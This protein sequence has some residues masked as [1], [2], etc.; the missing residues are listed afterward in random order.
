MKGWLREMRNLAGIIGCCVLGLGL[1]G[2]RAVAQDDALLRA[3]EARRTAMGMGAMEQPCIDKLFRAHR[4]K[5]SPATILNADFESVGVGGGPNNWVTA[6]IPALRTEAIEG[7]GTNH[8]ARI[9]RVSYY[10][11]L[12]T[13]PVPA[14]QTFTVGARVR[15]EYGEVR[16]ALYFEGATAQVVTLRFRFVSRSGVAPQDWGPMYAS[17]TRQPDEGFFGFIVR[18]AADVSWADMDDLFVVTEE[19]GNGGFEADESGADP[20]VRW[21]LTGD[22][23]LTMAEPLEGTTSLSLGSGA[24]AERLVAHTPY[25]AEYFLAGRCDGELQVSEARLTSGGDAAEPVYTQ[26]VTPGVGGKF[27]IPSIPLSTDA[28]AAVV[29]VENTGGADVRV[30]ELSRG[31][32][33][34]W[35]RRFEPVANSP[36]PSTRLTAAWPGKLVAAEVAILDSNQVEQDRLTNGDLQHDGTSVWAEYD[37]G[38]LPAGN[39]TA[40]FELES[41]DGII[42]VDRAFRIE[43]PAAFPTRL[44]DLNFPEFAR[45]PWMWL[46]PFTAET[47]AQVDT[48]D[49]IEGRLAAA[50]DDGFNFFFIIAGYFQLPM[51]KEAAER[52]GV[53]YIVGSPEFW[54]LF[55]EVYGNQT[56]EP[57]IATRELGGFDALLESEL[58][59]GIYLFDEPNTGGATMVQR[60]QGAALMMQAEG[61]YPAGMTFLS[62]GFASAGANFPIHSTYTYPIYHRQLSGTDSILDSLNIILP[63]IAEANTLGR[64]YWLGTQGFGHLGNNGV[65]TPEECTAQLGTGLVAGMRGYWP[66]LYTSLG[67]LA[68]LRTHAYGETDRLVAYRHFNARVAALDDLLMALPQARSAPPQSNV[69]ARVAQH[70]TGGPHALVANYHVDRPLQVTVQASASTR[71]INVETG[72][73]TAEGTSHVALLPAGDWAIFRFENG[74]TPTEFTG[75]TQAGSSAERPAAVAF[76]ASLTTPADP[77]SLTIKPDGTAVAYV[78]DQ[79]HRVS[80]IATGSIG[81]TLLDETNLAFLGY[82]RYLDNTRLVLGSRWLGPRVY[83]QTGTI[84]SPLHTLL[85]ESGNG[86]DLLLNGNEAW[87]S[88]NYWGVSRVDFSGVSG[89]TRVAHIFSSDNDFRS[90]HGPF[91]DGSV[92]GVETVRGLI[93]LE[94][95]GG[96]ITEERLTPTSAYEYATMSPGGRIAVGKLDRKLSVYDIGADGRIAD[97]TLVDDARLLEAGM[98]AWISE[99]VVAVADVRKGVRFY[100]VGAD[101]Y[102]RALGL[103]QP[104]QE[105]FIVE[106]LAAL[107]D[108]TVAAGLLPKRIVIGD[109]SAVLSAGFEQGWVAE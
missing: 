107:P 73:M 64:D 59:R 5:A 37:G 36:R 7:G 17:Y 24:R 34:V 22:A 48:V 16:P 61:K 39:Y 55:R 10:G 106:C 9:N 100:R 51:V 15:A 54:P 45:M 18:T 38:G 21:T 75:V 77:R 25:V 91:A 96:T 69:F 62:S 87:I 6:G 93:R 105:P 71:M 4:G 46:Y 14:W 78:Y 88:E 43:R 81:T 95:S 47:A 23:S 83:T 29:A 74:A 86:V 2:G 49:K 85:R 79:N 68:S 19:I 89:F 11:Q 52:V 84:F 31:W 60:V 98:T 56:W 33:C 97:E 104:T 27:L 102:W 13:P 76:T 30:D 32:A 109:A 8:Y 108:G 99:D 72:A 41:A 28:E 103:W 1:P 63:Q 82:A 57:G 92:V 53:P 20:R 80:S 3:A 94:E 67:P 42:A 40:R 70:P 12:I 58:F 50:R 26:S 90:I 35:P 66:F 101:G 65:M 44:D